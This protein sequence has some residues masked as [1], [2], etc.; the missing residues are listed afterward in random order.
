MLNNE[1]GLNIRDGLE[2]AFD[3]ILP[4]TVPINYT[5]KT[6]FKNVKDYG[7]ANAFLTDVNVTLDYYLA[8]DK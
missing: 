4:K 3:E 6:F 8:G 1:D 2:F 5:P 7:F